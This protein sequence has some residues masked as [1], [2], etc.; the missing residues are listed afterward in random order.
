MSI[1]PFKLASYARGLRE[2]LSE[3]RLIQPRKKIFP[4]FFQYKRVRWEGWKPSLE[5]DEE[6]VAEKET[7]SFDAEAMKYLRYVLVP[8][9]IG[10]S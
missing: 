3:C 10:E 6:D 2:I 7:S 1:S 5:F 4:F 9:L 8:I